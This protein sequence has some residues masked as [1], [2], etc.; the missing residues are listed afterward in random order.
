M[1][2][3]EREASLAVLERALGAARTIGQIVTVSGEAGIGK[4]SLLQTFAG[5]GAAGARVLW[6]YCEALGTP[7]PL[8][9][10]LDMAPALGGLTAEALAA[11]SPPHDVFAAFIGDL[12]RRGP[13]IVAVFEDVHWADEA[14]LDLLKYA[15]RRISQTRAVI[16]VSWRDDEVDA[17]HSIHRVLGDWPHAAVH[18]I[19]LQRLSIAAIEQLAAGTRDADAVHALTG[20]NPFFVTEV[21]SGAADTVPASVREAVLARR[22]RLDAPARAVLDLVSVVPLRLEP[23]LLSSALDPATVDLEACVTA[24]LLCFEPQGVSFRHE[25]ARLAVADA[26]PPPRVQDCH[27]RVLNA[28][29]ARPDRDQLLARIVHHAEASGDV[30]ALLEHAPAAARQAAALGAHRQAVEHYRRA[31]AHAGRLSL[32]ARAELTEALAY[33]H[34]LTSD[35]DAARE[36]Q[37]AALEL[38]RRLGA[39]LAVGR[40]IRWLSRLAWFAGDR[41]EAQRRADEAIAVLGELP[42]SRELA[43]AFSNRSQLDMLSDDLASSVAWGAKAIDLARSL[44]ATEVLSHALN[45][46]GTVRLAAG[47]TEG[48]AQLEESLR[49]ALAGEFHEHAARAYTNLSSSPIERRDYDEARRWLQ[50]GINYCAE[51]DLDSW[52]LYMLAWRARLSAESGLWQSAC[53]D[54][55]A[56]LAAPRLAAVNRLSALTALGLVS[57]RRG[58]P[59]ADR[60]LD[61]ALAL[62]RRTG[63]AQR[64]VPVLVARAELAWFTGRRSGIEEAVAEGLAA[65]GRSALPCKQEHLLYWLAKSGAPRVDKVEG[66]GPYA[67]LMRGDWMAAATHWQRLGC[68]YERGEALVE[69]DIA[70]V[71]EALDIFQTLAAAP[72]ADRARQRL[73]QMGL[74]RVPRGRRPSTRAHPAGLTAREAEVL[75]M[76][77]LDLRNPQIADRLFV[78][79]K[80]VEHHVSSILAKLGVSTRDA[81]VAGARQQGWLTDRRREQ[82]FQER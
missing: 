28:L 33:E 42:E 41:D 45:N 74:V 43:M 23:G 15:G 32:E 7:R 68:P 34:Y 39:P 37:R 3:V 64:L 10:L 51:R 65:L 57:V 80:T 9:P 17:D 66:D 72:A 81:A 55:S 77:A 44:G 6:G 20:G 52:K 18:R 56:V 50:P 5:R 25:M 82:V 40:N 59:G 22:A 30:D 8:G 38:W 53:D 11:G 73:R 48:R 19:E 13:P 62:A 63:E 76:L 69:G 67:Q 27:R 14:T 36:A 46:V 12:A 24:G 70:A 31:L 78:S 26:L 49:L 21:L 47:E 29:V 79:P 54:A 16:V 4:S 71:R 2:L 75:G 58:D 1:A 35:I 60:L 61:E